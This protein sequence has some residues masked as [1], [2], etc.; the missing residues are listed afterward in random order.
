MGGWNALG[1]AAYGNVF[2][3]QRYDLTQNW[4][5]LHIRGAQLG[6]VTNGTN[7]VAGLYVTNSAMIPFEAMIERWARADPT[8]FEARF[9]ARGISGAF[10][11][12]IELQIRANGHGQLGDLPESVLASF[13]PVSG[14]VVDRLA[15]EFM[16]PA[17]DQ[18]VRA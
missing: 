2:L 8:R 3:G 15:G 7:L 6:G 14:R 18:R 1:A 13:D 4:E 5:W 17:I 9:L 10:C 16:K 12:R 11:H